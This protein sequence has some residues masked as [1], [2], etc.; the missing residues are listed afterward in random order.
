[1]LKQLVMLLAAYA[2]HTISNLKK[3]KQNYFQ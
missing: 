3:Q 1:M 2:G